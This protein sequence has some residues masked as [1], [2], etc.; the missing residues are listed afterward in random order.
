MQ[1]RFLCFGIR[2]AGVTTIA[3]VEDGRVI[4]KTMPE[5]T[6]IQLITAKERMK[7]HG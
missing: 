2:H 1:N 3:Y 5:I 4:I 6:K 7:R